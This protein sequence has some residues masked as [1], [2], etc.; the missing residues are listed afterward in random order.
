MRILV[1]GGAG[2]IGSHLVDRL[3][4][5]GHDVDVIDDL[6]TGSLVNLTDARRNNQ[7]KFS[8]HRLDIRSSAVSD[9]IAKSRPDIVMHLG[10]QT[11][12]AASIAK[13]AIDAD[14]NIG[15]SINVLE[16]CARA[17]VSKV[18]FACT[19][20]IYGEPQSL[21]LREGHPLV[22]LS[23]YA[24]SKKAVLDYLYAYRAAQGVE[25]VALVLA[26]VYGPRQNA[27]QEG[28]AVARFAAQMLRRERPTI[29]GDGAQTR[30]FIFVD[31]VVDAFVRS[32]DRGSGLAMNVGTG[33]STSIQKLFDVIASKTSYKDP[34]RYAPRRE[35]EI[36]DSV[37]DYKRAELHLG[38]SPF[39]P[40]EDGIGRTIEWYRA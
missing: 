23:P 3:L 28:G 38:F 36:I 33:A 8:F 16:G 30:D 6:S 9:T 29:F 18:I 39:T 14:I 20:G 26:N 31:D 27:H 19:A 22:P 40:I 17:K 21:P 7:R 34:A 13:P 15:G 5:E 24:I 37:L 1:T 12:V 25:Y 11:D 10:A 2:F 32:I 4:A 35:G